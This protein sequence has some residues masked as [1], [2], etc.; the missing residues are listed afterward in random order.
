MGDPISV[1]QVKN[2][3]NHCR[4]R[5]RRG[6][7]P[8][9][10]RRSPTPV[11]PAV[12]LPRAR[13]ISI[14]GV[15][16]SRLLSLVHCSCLWVATRVGA[17]RLS[18]PRWRAGRLPKMVTRGARVWH[19][20][21][22]GNLTLGPGR[23]YPAINRRPGPG[24]AGA[25]L[26]LVDRVGGKR[27]SVWIMR[28]ARGELIRCGRWWE[29]SDRAAPPSVSRCAGWWAWRGRKVRGPS[30]GLAARMSSAYGCLVC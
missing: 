9:L 27:L 30:C 5:R 14:A 25:P 18:G 7:V 26:R 13:R 19:G 24:S 4:S 20:R 10:L 28:P 21:S 6:T 17:S 11:L 2:E 29:R 23:L 15:V 1:R 16:A 12:A 3:Q 8:A 22:N